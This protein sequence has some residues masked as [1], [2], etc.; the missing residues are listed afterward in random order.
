MPDNTFSVPE[1]DK[2]QPSK[3]EV[4][5]VPESSVLPKNYTA[6]STEAPVTPTYEPPDIQDKYGPPSPAQNSYINST[7][8]PGLGISI[9]TISPSVETKHSPEKSFWDNV[10]SLYNEWMNG[11]Q[12]TAKANQGYYWEDVKPNTL[13]YSIKGMPV[14]AQAAIRQRQDLLNDIQKSAPVGNEAEPDPFT[15]AE[16]L[17]RL[18]GVRKFNDIDGMY[19]EDPNYRTTLNAEV[20]KLSSSTSKEMTQELTG[21]KQLYTSQS[22]QLQKELNDLTKSKSDEPVSVYT[23]S[24]VPLYTKTKTKEETNTIDKAVTDKTAQLEELNQTY[25]EVLGFYGSI[26]NSKNTIT[27]SDKVTAPLKQLSASPKDSPVDWKSFF[28]TLQQSLD[29]INSFNKN[30]DLIKTMTNLGIDYVNVGDSYEAFRAK[31]RLQNP[32]YESEALPQSMVDYWTYNGI[33]NNYKALDNSLQTD[34][35]I[36]SQ[37]TKARENTIKD[38]QAKNV[39]ISVIDDQLNKSGLTEVLRLWTSIADYKSKR[40]Y[41]KGRS[42]KECS[43]LRN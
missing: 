34:L 3:N 41:Y 37:I 19:Y 2:L 11:P 27:A 23:E 13:D 4:F 15:E 36:I 6:S 14:K 10:K 29:Y 24:G 20:Q 17:L 1:S 39:P 32:G 28:P 38:A 18:Q 42:S 22:G 5:N 25:Q 31:D 16:K 40:K 43:N 9:A 35:Q 21:V 33:R 12:G 26:A 30:P 7:L 8:D